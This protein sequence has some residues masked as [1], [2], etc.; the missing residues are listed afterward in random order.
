MDARRKALQNPNE[1]YKK[2]V[3]IVSRYSVHNTGISF[4]LEK[5]SSYHVQ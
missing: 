3:D 2:I 4:T 5:V 1:E